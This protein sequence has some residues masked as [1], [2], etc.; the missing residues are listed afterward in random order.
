M[1]FQG[2][3]NANTAPRNGNVDAMHVQSPETG[4]EVT[5][6]SRVRWAQARGYHAK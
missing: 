5:Y 6:Y 2:E 3:N 4:L 1:R